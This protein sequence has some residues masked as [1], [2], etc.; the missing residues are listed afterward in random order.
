MRYRVKDGTQFV[1]I[2]DGGGPG[3][4]IAAIQ[5][6][7]PGLKTALAECEYHDEICL[8]WVAIQP[9]LCGNRLKN[10]IH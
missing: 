2:S 9:W 1:V 3:V 6:V 5:A 10:T 8:N 7:Q 4:S